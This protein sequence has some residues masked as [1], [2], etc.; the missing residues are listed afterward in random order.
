MVWARTKLVIFE[1][2][3]EDTTDI[4]IRYSGPY[5]ERFYK[6][7]L[8]DLEKTFGVHR[9][10]IQ[11]IDYAWEK[12]DGGATRFKIWWRLVK[13]LDIFSYL[14]IDVKLDGESAENAG[15]AIIDIK[16]ALVTEYPQDTVIQQSIFYEMMRRF[17]H[18]FFYHKKR[19]QYMILGRDLCTAFEQRMKAFA[20]EL[21]GEAKI[22]TAKIT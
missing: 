4:F 3:F 8:E 5:P 20:E 18:Q 16:P 11:E 19:M 1:D 6:R 21:R 17:W 7:V 13:S 10:D 22:E 9:S 14:R 12:H 2:V 15:Y